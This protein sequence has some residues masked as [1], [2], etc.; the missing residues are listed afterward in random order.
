[1]WFW[2]FVLCVFWAS[3]QTRKK[4]VVFLYTQSCTYTNKLDLLSCQ[5]PCSSHT[6]LCTCQLND[7]YS[8]HWLSKV[9]LSFSVMQSLIS[10]ALWLSSMWRG[11]ICWHATV[12]VSATRKK[13][14]HPITQRTGILNYI[15]LQLRMCCGCNVTQTNNGWKKIL[16]GRWCWATSITFATAASVWR[17]KP[18]YIK[19]I[20]LSYLKRQSSE[21]PD[22]ACKDK[23]EWFSRSF[24]YRVYQFVLFH[25]Y[26]DY[27]RG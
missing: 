13:D 1:M 11:R 8:Y 2:A 4:P 12:C 3:S 25:S 5:D 16:S 15:C 26:L 22:L 20:D 17:M 7:T 27:L 10:S 19:T 24:F 18:P 9:F 6:F 23:I 21:K 14:T